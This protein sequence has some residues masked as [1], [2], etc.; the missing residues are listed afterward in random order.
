[1]QDAKGPYAWCFSHGVL[2]HFPAS[3]TPWCSATWAWLAG[4]SS[5]DALAAKTARFGEARFLDALPPTDQLAL[6]GAGQ[7]A[8]PL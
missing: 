1:M 2:H 5:E 4:E 6:L 3:S 7:T 8:G